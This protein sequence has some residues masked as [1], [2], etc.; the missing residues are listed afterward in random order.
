MVMGWE[1]SEAIFQQARGRMAQGEI[2][3]H[4]GALGFSSWDTFLCNKCADD[5]AHYE[6][7]V[8]YERDE[9]DA[10]ERGEPWPPGGGSPR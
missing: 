7:M 6:M 9:R 5:A 3:E 4:G 8:D 10:L 2:C 1:I